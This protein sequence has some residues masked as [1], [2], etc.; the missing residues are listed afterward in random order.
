V[1]P[2]S[3]AQQR[4]W[5]L[6]MMEQRP[7]Y[8]V[9][10]AL[11]LRGPLRPDVL[12][13]ALA[14]VV[15]RH[16][17]LRTVFPAVDG[18]PQQQIVADARP[19]ILTTT[20]AEADLPAA[21]TEAA[22]YVFDLTTE[23]P[24][25]PYLFRT[26]ADD[27]TF[28]LVMHH[29][30]T[31]GGSM[32]PL[33]RDLADAYTARTQDEV[34]QW[35]PL[36]VQYADYTLWQQELLGAED[37]PE[38]LLARE[39]RY[40]KEQLAGIPEE[41]ALPTDRPRPT[42]PSFRGDAVPFR[43]D[44]ATHSGL[45][46]LARTSQTTLFMV[47][48]ASL[49]TLLTR[50]GA[51]TD[52]P[53]GFPI[54]G[55]GDEALDDLVGFFVNTLVLRTDTSGDPTFREL[56]GRVRTTNLAA[57]SNQDVPFDR[58]VE[59]VNP[60]R[61]LAR[62]PL[63]QVMLVHTSG[64]AGQPVTF[65]DL[66]AKVVKTG[67]G[68]AKFD[69]TLGV[70]E[71][72][73]GLACTLEYATDLFDRAT[74]EGLAWRLGRVVEQVLAAPDAPIGQVQT[75]DAA[76][77]QQLL[78]G[79]NPPA[80][81]VQAQVHE[82]FAAQAALTPDRTAL[83]HRDQR[84]TYAELDARADALA[85]QLLDRGVAPGGIVGVHLE[86]T[87]E[88]VVALLAVLKAGAGYT[89]LDPTFPVDRLAAVLAQAGASLLVSSP[90]LD[91]DLGVPWIDVDA[92]PAGPVSVAGDVACVI[93]TSG[94][95][96]EPKGV[97]LPHRAIIGTLLGQEYAPFGAD[98]VWLQAAPMSW[99]A[100]ATEVFGPL[101]HGGTCVLQP[102]E[103]PEPQVM[104]DLVRE[105][106]VTVLKGSASLLNHLLDEHPAI[107]GELRGALTGGEPASMAHAATVLRDFPDVTL[108]NGYGPAESMGFTTTHHITAPDLERASI[109][110]G[111]PVAGKRAYVLDAQ[112]DPVPA[113]VTGE[114]YV[115]GVGLAHGYLNKPGLS[116]ERFVANPFGTG[117]RMYRT[118]D[119]ARWTRTGV[120][121]YQ[122]RADDQVKIRG[123]RV[124]PGEIQNVLVK[125]DAVTQ[126]AVVVREDQPGDRRLVAYVVGDVTDLRQYLSDRL[127]DYL[128]PSAFVALDALP[129]TPNG[130]LDRRAL[131]APQIEVTGT[132]PRTPQE[133]ILC[134]LFAEVLKTGTVGIDDNFFE[135]GGHSLL[136]MRLISRIRTALGAELTVRDLFHAPTVAGLATR[137]A[138]GGVTRLAL[139]AVARPERLPL[140]F[141]QQ[142]LWV[143]DQMD[144]QSAV[145][146]CP[147]ALRLR[148]V[149]DRVALE[150][151]IAD[152]VERHEVLRTVF[153]VVGG[154][155]CQQVVTA[156]P[157]L[158]LI[159]EDAMQ[160][161]A[162]RPFDLA[163]EP[164]IRAY[165]AEVGP[166]EH[167]LLLVLH[168]IASD[169]WSRAPLMR[170]LATAY[171][172]RASQGAPQW[173]DLPVQYADYTLW[174]QE[175]LG[176]ADD[177]E[178]LLAEQLAYW[179][180]TLTG[181]PDQLEL[182]TDRPRPAVSSHG[183]DAVRAEFDAEGHR[184][185]LEL[186]RTNQT[187]LFMVL[188]AGIAALLT[189]LGAGTDIPIGSPIAGRSDEALEDLVGFFVNTL[190]LRTDTSGDPTFRELLAR[191]RE[192]DLGAYAHQDVPFERLVE[193]LNPARSLSR[194]PLFQVMLVLQNNAEASFALAGL[195]VE[196]DQAGTGNAKFDLALA[197]AERPSG[198][199]DAYLQYATDLFDRGTAESLLAGLVRLLTA[200]AADPDTFLSRVEL[201]SGEERH[202]LLVRWN[203]TGTY[204]PAETVPQQVAAQARRTPD[205]VA[206]VAGDATVTYAE[207]D[208]RAN[209][210]AHHLIALGVTPGTLVGL[211]VSRRP[212]MV[213]GALA[214]LKAGG[215]YVPLDPNY[216]AERLA[217][218]LGDAATPVVLTEPDLRDR[219][220][221]SGAT[222]V[223]VDQVPDHPTSTPAVAV[224]PDDTAYVIYT[225]G[226]TGAPKG[227]VIEHRGLT[228]L[229]T[230]HNRE[231]AI[232]PDDRAS[233]VAAQGFDAAVWEVWPYLCAGASVH[234][235]DQDTLDD[236]DAL[237]RW[238]IRSGLTIC[239]LPTPRLESLLDEPALADT[240]LRAILTGG[241]ALRRRP[242]H[243]LPFRVVNHYGPTEFSVVAT[244]ADV[245][246]T[247]AHAEEPPPIGGPVDNTRLYVLDS[248]LMPVPQ[249][250]IGELYIAGEGLA[251]GYLARPGL[252]AQ[253]FVA[254]PFG[255]P[256]ERM[257]RTGDLVK[258]RT[259]GHLD[260][261]GRA[262]HQVK[263]RGFRIELGEIE[264]VL[265][266]HPS[267]SQVAV[268]VRED[269][270]GIKTLAAYVV[271]R[272]AQPEELRR[273]VAEF[274]P[275]YMVPSAFVLMDA[276]PLTPNGKLDRRALPAPDDAQVGYRGPRTPHEELL[277][278][279]FAEVLCVAEVGIDDNFFDLGGHSLL[280]AR[281]I[282]RVRTALGAELSVRDL[283]QAPTVA[284][285]AGQL[286]AVQ[287]AR[288]A[289][290]PAQ[291][292]G[293]VPLS[294]AQRRLWFV[295]RLDGANATYCVPVA[296]RLRG[297]LD[298]TALEAAIG[299]VVT[300][301]EALRTIFP[302]VD[303]EPCQRIVDT[304]PQMTVVECA[305]TD[306]PGVLQEAAQRTFDL[307]V[308]PPIRVWLLAVAPAEHVLLLA[309]HHIASDGAS[310]G[311]LLRDLAEAYE[312][313][314][315]GD[316]P[317]WTPPP[318]QYADYTLWQQELL[319]SA[320]DP[321]SLG[322]RQ[323]AYWQDALAGIPEELALPADR[324]RPAVSTYDGGM[325]PLVLDAELHRALMDLA[326]SSGTTLFMVLQAGVA[327]LLTRLGAGTDIPIGAPVAGRS[328]EA[329]EDLVGFFVNTL[330]LRTDTSGDPTFR[331]LLA[332]V[333]ETDL[334]AYAHQDVPFERLVEEL[335]PARSLSRHPL[336]QVML[337]LQNTG[338]AS[339]EI[340]GLEVSAEPA[341]T[342]RA[343]FDLSFT[344]REAY[345][346]GGAPAGIE[347]AIGY[348]AD[349]F[350][351]GTARR[352]AE[353]L[354][355][356][357]RAVTAD[358]GA[359]LLGVDLL[360]PVEEYRIVNGWNDTA[361]PVVASTLPELFAEQVARTPDATAVVFEDTVLTYAE[362]DTRA[363]RLARA[364]VDRGAG[365]ERI[366]A[367]A[368][369]RSV[370]LIV[371]LYAV[372]KAGAAYLPVDPE[373][374][375]DRLELMLADAD[376]VLV[377]D[378]D[379][380]RRLEALDAEAELP[381]IDPGHPAYVI[382]TS[383]S[384][385]RPKGVVVPHAGIVNRLVWMQAEYGLDGSDRVLQKTPS[386]FDVSV[387]E[388]FWPLLVGATLVV[389]RPG[390]HKDPAY[391][392][393]L[394]QRERVTT[395]H[396]VPSMLEA[397][398]LA[399][400]A[401][402]CTSLHR[403][404][405]S[406]E[407]LPTGLARRFAAISGAGLHNLYGP[408]EASVD[409]T[410]YQYRDGDTT[411]S[412]P[413]GRPV[414][415]T[416][417]YVLDAALRPVP[418]RVPGELYLAGVQL[419]RG[420][421]NRP[422]LS[423]ERFVA[424][425]FDAGTRMYRTGDI[426]RWCGDGV[427]EY[428]SRADD[429][430]KIRGFRIELGEIANVAGTHPD[431]DQAAVVV[432][433]D[434]PGDKRLVA[435]VVGTVDPAEL[436]R[437][438]AAALP[439]YMVPA[440]VVRID[441]LPLSPSGKLDRRAL[442]APEFGGTPSGRAPRTQREEVLC[443]LF[444]EVL[445][446]PA[447]S[448]D[449]NFFEFGGHSLLVTRLVS[450]IRREL[451]AELSIRGL[452]E[453]PTVAELAERL[454]SYADHDPLAVLLPLR[455]SGGA[456]PL[457]CIHP[458]AGIGWVYSGLLRHVDP[459]TPVYGLQARG[460]TQLDARPDTVAAMVKNYL[461][462]VRI[463]QPTGP[464]QLLG[465]S[466]GARIAHAMAARLRGEGDEVAL[467][468][469]LDGYP[470]AEASTRDLRPDDPEVRAALL[471][472][473]GI[474]EGGS[475]DGV[476]M[477]VLA[478]V[479]AANL[480]LMGEAT[481]ELFDGDAVF[482]R[483]A[484]DK[485][486]GSPR[487]EE[488]R[489][490]LTGDLEVHDV[491]C[492]HGAMT[493]PEPIA[494]I[495][496]VLNT[497]I[498]SKE[499]DHVR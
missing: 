479:F 52:I 451:G 220:A 498:R 342:G 55:R 218:M 105:H 101:F 223:D 37:D 289:L 324:L 69:L 212:E 80:A 393:D 297:A 87:P 54:A 300:R 476:D 470:A 305:E 225:S 171:E 51:G 133:E 242:S 271:G 132:A 309:M 422:G 331:E 430:V 277:C 484:V 343:N 394:I 366:V 35:E 458:A 445:G 129:M 113:G 460:L 169:G 90:D 128:V 432:R 209:Q 239:F 400:E 304:L 302:E 475:V 211:C 384:T 299:D 464:Y 412:V 308:D 495:G 496:R 165:L 48:Q 232:S 138:S 441:G 402:G 21:L 329:L 339:L 415:N 355:R 228:D 202:R 409:V 50:L 356:L 182:P 234:L 108:T 399:P 36:P 58:L 57:Y 173:T 364:L 44:A 73:D 121:D 32:G 29:I 328:D 205:A 20:V 361:V 64:G 85:R 316:A 170:D 199:L 291:R 152:V 149:L 467:L 74:V 42:E 294:F 483:A 146:N 345:G 190:V 354:V 139:R 142:R 357:L 189:R 303:G 12:E 391:L 413:I 28:V 278:G 227:V 285:L 350:E 16:E 372:H 387:W 130:K 231:Y 283:F 188:Q 100:F 473:L 352:L 106:G 251:R 245:P 26:A 259:D 485:H 76:E 420:Y 131:P 184:A 178:S 204:V 474:A 75:V 268:L 161:A 433:E 335:N 70:E 254:N 448:I 440:A 40:W 468:A 312:A 95:T 246:A 353:R 374:P 325:V 185:L 405:C 201:L 382:Y 19:A 295:N 270:P 127:P 275:E 219:L 156:R 390:G 175:L 482:F 494:V 256:G 346:D 2:L 284:G 279:V 172:A 10:L 60:E 125:H 222:I 31:D 79:W 196:A 371:A 341:G 25:R 116:A 423:A 497:H 243:E 450:R 417:V 114:L 273:R 176:S 158:E 323:L 280:A 334:G 151:A 249:G 292:G 431:V 462:Q 198:G 236:T 155:P 208:R 340:P 167:V 67:T 248:N 487:P 3:Y 276:L 221:G 43:F 252:T 107:F 203:D 429:Q 262:D 103:S 307:T 269:R 112:L 216:P 118:G 8:N 333:R 310:M 442:P 82:V 136:A 140:S 461:D 14:D 365:M 407:A 348:R 492:T 454:D 428:L 23:L 311:P 326:K 274:L 388:F 120:L 414:W 4:L 180:D 359:P 122:G 244:A 344:L 363:D 459:E 83:V 163:T 406:G 253:R 164:P 408:T 214:V 360:D 61:S 65:G 126:A 315:A 47:L 293:W 27:H 17:A 250:V 298:R 403:V 238:M 117:E 330:V 358:P 94:S 144:G 134:G 206:I 46:E 264:A 137:L 336:F 260:F 237:L 385:G 383:G 392:A 480:A 81:S 38:S 389:A 193:E 217:Y 56:L 327:A 153:P 320:D 197:F 72:A 290:R 313:R 261:A 481:A 141:A 240:R 119:L 229:C 377:L 424:N 13:S 337:A 418:P 319:G 466:F 491:A 154:H 194:H 410:S 438:V 296:L 452:F 380:I 192:T 123:F 416:Q 398:V 286:A 230:W 88:L 447:V 78:Y 84:I 306:V 98:D 427:L 135:L 91:P 318:V 455:T 162:D 147:Y 367:V 478:E 143:I 210:L 30:A 301:H 102:G 160:D 435:Y 288:P 443:G 93:F 45:Q 255:T 347:G 124:E 465:W 434:R 62:H 177:P 375:A 369:P 235:P 109:P 96:G 499:A 59:Q 449:A 439:E 421:L 22:R 272:A 66:T 397:F 215:A 97:V 426:V 89:L 115:A 396:F 370:E 258:W 446:V 263:V 224:T 265:A 395:V 317:Q 490:H 332:R 110:I 349:L 111:A 411:A 257:Y 6:S 9:P 63:F 15:D 226:S 49:A 379:T 233:Q 436:R 213:I 99:D 376:P 404:I 18:Q 419:A 477:A 77:R 166:D 287:D 351:P 425:P 281:L 472:S 386:S 5:F 437:H 338:R 53:I 33:V 159:T 1:I 168:H 186:A 314:L 68:S 444:A 181:A 247:G 471:A 463:V 7:T 453:T 39:L 24:I 92:P 493:Q 207:L 150:A 282:S 489:A 457:F 488:W 362:L 381:R 266:Q 469:L 191:V 368:V 378:A 34:P 200:V 187:T 401:A 41:L 195:D 174:Q 373:Y 157:A 241:D 148:G 321:E 267:V 104:A 11:R 456:T 86:R 145:Y 486:A 322:A 71:T 183:G 179:R